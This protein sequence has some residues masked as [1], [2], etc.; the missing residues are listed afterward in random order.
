MCK[1]ATN[2][3]F[4]DLLQRSRQRVVQTAQRPRL[5]KIDCFYSL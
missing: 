1:P 5:V 2:I 3:S 4:R